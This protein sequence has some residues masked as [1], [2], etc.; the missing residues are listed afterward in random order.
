[1]YISEVK[2]VVK[3]VLDNASIVFIDDML[4]KTEIGWNYVYY[5]YELTYDNNFI[6]YSKFC[7]PLEKDKKML[8]DKQIIFLY[9]LNCDY[10]AIDFEDENELE[11]YL[12]N[13]LEKGYDKGDIREFSDFIVNGT[14]GFN[15]Y[16]RNK[17]INN[18]IYSMELKVN[19]KN[20]ICQDLKFELVLTDTEEDHTLFLNKVNNDW[21]VEIKDKTEK[22]KSLNDFYKITIDNIYK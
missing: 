22:I 6:A 5:F 2:K 3:K 9:S 10:Y 18:F 19:K 4:E 8:R 17:N 15:E 21:I 13:F 16:F 11:Q 14:E 12:I 1:M 7:F 20:T